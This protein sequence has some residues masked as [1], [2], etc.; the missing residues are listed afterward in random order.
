MTLLL[1]SI[2]LLASAVSFI[3]MWRDKRA[4]ERGRW[5]TPESTLHL[6]ELAGGWPGSFAAQRLLRHKNRKVGYQVIFWAC[7]V[8]DVGIVVWLYRWRG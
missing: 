6:L 4:A 1:L 3:A 2:V 8:I 5:R 7:V